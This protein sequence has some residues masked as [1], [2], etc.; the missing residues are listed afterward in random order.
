MT[1]TT[2]IGPLVRAQQAKDAR[3]RD[4]S[5]GA[6]QE[7]VWLERRVRL[8]RPT[9]KALGIDTGE[10]EVVTD[11]RTGWPTSRAKLIW[12][13]RSTVRVVAGELEPGAEVVLEI[14]EWLV[15]KHGL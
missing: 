10:T 5:R 7:V 11:Q 1:T 15:R 4:V 3:A 2:G 12:L 6:K 8:G 14:P 9:E 13:A